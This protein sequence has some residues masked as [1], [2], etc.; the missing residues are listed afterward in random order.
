MPQLRPTAGLRVINA[1]R[2]SVD[3]GTA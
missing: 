1:L 2:A 3:G